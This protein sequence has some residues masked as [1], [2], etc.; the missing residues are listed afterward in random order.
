M[1]NPLSGAAPRGP[2]AH[3]P[4]SEKRPLPGQILREKQLATRIGTGAPL[5]PAPRPESAERV[6]LASSLAGFQAQKQFRAGHKAEL[7]HFL[8]EVQHVAGLRLHAPVREVPAYVAGL[9]QRVQ[10]YHL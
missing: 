1:E 8:L 4:A 2:A 3:L 9:L 7:F 5:V 6:D 10:R